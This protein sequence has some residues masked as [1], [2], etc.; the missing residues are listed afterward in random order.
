IPFLGIA[1]IVND[2]LDAHTPSAL[3][4][5]AVVFEADAWARRMAANLVSSINR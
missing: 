5:V 4:D 3:T 2:V 1:A